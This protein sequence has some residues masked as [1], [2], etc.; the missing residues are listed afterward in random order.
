MMALGYY[1]EGDQ[2]HIDMQFL[3]ALEGYI[4]I[5]PRCGHL[6]VGICGKGEPAASLRRRLEAYLREREIRYDD[7]R[8]YA[9]CC[10]RSSAAPGT[11]IAS[12]ATGGWRSATPRAWWIR[13]PAKGST[14]R[15]ARPTWPRMRCWNT[16]L[17]KRPPRIAPRW[18][19]I[20]PRE[21]R[22]RRDHRAALFPRPLSVRSGPRAHGA[23]HAPQPAIRGLD[24]GSV[25]RHAILPRTQRRGCCGTSRRPCSKSPWPAGNGVPRK[26]HE[27]HQIRSPLRARPQDHSRRRQLA[28]ARVPQRGRQLRCSS[29]AAKARTS[30]TSMATSTSTTSA[31]GDRCCWGIGIRRSWRRSNAALDHRHQLRRAHRTESRAGRG[32]PRRRAVDARWCAW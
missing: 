1:I 9:T 22:I 21:S 18:R 24:A 4:W 10:R 12:R 3:R 19:A 32:D 14:T 2:T 5:F 15:F 13:S 31:P 6:S 23:V 28:G 20:S 7:A 17:W 26:H 8:F 27:A 25:R 29:R 30:S 16:A 11:R